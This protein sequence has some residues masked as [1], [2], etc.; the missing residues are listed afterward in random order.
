MTTHITPSETQQAIERLRNVASVSN[1]PIHQYG[2]DILT[3]CDAAE[4]AL[5]VVEA[6]NAYVRCKDGLE[7]DYRLLLLKALAA[8]EEQ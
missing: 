5:R 1:E 4:K 7:C 2:L 8:M 6:A 3:V